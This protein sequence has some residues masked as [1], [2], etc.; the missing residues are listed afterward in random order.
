MKYV[1]LIALA[2]CSPHGPD[3][4]AAAAEGAYTA[5]L[6]RCVDKSATLAESKA[7]RAEVNKKW[8]ITEVPK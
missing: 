6:T 3:P 4:K 7:C 5:D 2:G 1:I 8:G